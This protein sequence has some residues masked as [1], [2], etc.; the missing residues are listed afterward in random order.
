M[1]QRDIFRRWRFI[2]LLDGLILVLFFGTACAT[3]TGAAPAT[4][5]AQVLQ[6]STDVSYPGV[7]GVT[8]AGTLLIP[9]HQQGKQVPGV[10]IVAGSGPVDRN[11]NAAGGEQSNMYEQFAE[12]LAQHGIASLRYDK[13][14]VGTSTPVPLPKDPRNPTS[15]EIVALQQFQAWQNFVG[16]AA[17]SLRYLQSQP[18]ID[19]SHTALLG[20]SEGTYISEVVATSA[21]SDLKAPVALVLAGAPGRPIDQVLREQIINLLQRQR[22]SVAVENFVLQ[23]Y[24]AIIA[25]IKQTGQIPQRPLLNVEINPRVPLAVRQTFAEEFS[26]TLNQFWAG[27]LRVIPTTLIGEYRGPVLLL[28]GTSDPNVFANED[29]PLMNTALAQRP[30]DDHF[31]LLVPGASHYLKVVT[32]GNVGITGPIVPQVLSTLPSWL[33]QKLR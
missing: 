3:S 8:L 11:G 21:S 29:T 2:S 31:T 18:M 16:D 12:D 25:G 22:V 9:A 4:S 24:D 15:A 23:Q 1:Q 33:N 13:R 32:A 19:S 27:E 26:I 28:Q 14:G 20:H 17:A 30:Q 6:S 10:V 5:Q 7:N